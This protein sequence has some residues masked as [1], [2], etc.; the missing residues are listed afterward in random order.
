M[1]KINEIRIDQPSTD[2]DEFFELFGDANTSLDGLTYIVIGDGAAAA[3]S[4]VIESVTDLSG[5]SF[6]DNGF[7]VA[8]ESTFSLGTAN[9]TTTLG[10]ENSDNVTHLLVENFTGANGDD[11]DTDDDGILDITPFDSIVDS[12]ALIETVGSGEQVY[13][14]TQVGPDGS[15]VPAHVFR[16]VDG[17]GDF[18]IGAFDPIGGDDTA[19][20][21]NGDSDPEPEPEPEPDELTPIFDIQGAAL[22]SPL[23]GEEVTTTGIVTAV[24]TNGFYIQDPTGDGDDAT[25]DALFV[26]TGSAPGVEVGDELEVAGTVS[27]FTPGGASTGN[28][29]TTQISNATLTTLS[30]ENDL[31]EATIIGAGG[32][33]PPTESINDDPDSFNPDVD[34]IDFF[35]SLEGMLVTAQD[36]VAVA[37]TTRFGEIF[38]VVDGG[39]SA[40]G[41]SERGT[42]NISPDDFN[43]ERVQIDADSGI[44]PGFDFPE[45]DTGDSLGDVTGVVTFSFGNFEIN[46][47]EPFSVTPA[48]LEAEITGIE[49]GDD[50]LT[51]ATYNVLNLDPNDSDGDTDVADGRF[52]AIADDIVNSLD[53]PA[54]IGLQEIQDSSGSDNDG[55]ISAEETLQQLT[56]AIAANGGTQYEFIDNT[57]ITDNASGGQPGGNIRTAFL[58][59]PSRVSL[60]EDSVQ[61]IDSQLAGGAFE[62]TRLPLVASFEFNGEEVTVINNHFSSKGGSSPI[63]GVDQPFEDLQEDPNVNGGLDERQ[64]QAEAVD[65]FVDSIFA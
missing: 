27:E 50:D 64:V 1:Q 32:R 13:S 34:G 61:T 40:S 10:F 65:N 23:N 11:L 62:D 21:S 49:A 3:G 41:I 39:N 8:A 48:G 19:G 18:E 17:T 22:V 37:G 20:T 5:Q 51:I 38:T 12:V 53:S 35:E 52:E 57:F 43:P 26:F 46:P 28:L 42:L 15:F 47:T 44:L 59:D 9:L 4:G 24:D 60:V 54:I 2:N 56:D 55:T 29:S 30:T 7:F 31:P 6:D 58:Y 14:D 63:F 36:A 33:V 16:L 45:V 25:S